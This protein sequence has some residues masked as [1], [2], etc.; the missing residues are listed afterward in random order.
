MTVKHV[1]DL[2]QYGY[3]ANRKLFEVLPQLTVEQFTQ[4]VADN[5]GSIRNTLVHILSAEWG[6][7]E[8]CGGPAR[9]APLDPAHYPTAAALIHAWPQ[10][11]SRM[12]DF[13]STLSDSDLARPIEFS[14][15]GGP[16]QSLP[17]GKLLQHAANHGVHHR[18]QVSLL[19]R[20][21]GYSPDDFDILFYFDEKQ[22]APA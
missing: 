22:G 2:F 14:L 7:L 20:L 6:W 9:G 10:Q 8:R 16:K 11:Q 3:W 17:L 12:R 15:G 4:P 1:E 5:H 18:G 21:R 19:L 13:L